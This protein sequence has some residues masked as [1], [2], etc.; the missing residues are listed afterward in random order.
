M[1]II[2]LPH[3]YSGGPPDIELIA[4]S[5]QYIVRFNPLNL[6]FTDVHLMFFEGS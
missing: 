3:M 6:P 4:D 5:R 2:A 1:I